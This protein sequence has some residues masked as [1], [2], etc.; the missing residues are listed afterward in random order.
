M[1]DDKKKGI[2]PNTQNRKWL[3][4]FNNPVEHN[5]THEELKV[6]L[7]KI[8]GALYWCMCDEI[9]GKTQTY[10]TH[11][12]LY[13]SS[14][15]KF[16]Q[17]KKMF[18]SAH[19]DY[20]RGTNQEN[21]DYIRKEGK[22][23][24]SDKKETN[25]IDTFEESGECPEENQGSRNDLNELYDMI[26]NDYST[27]QILEVNPNYMKQIGTI[28]RI[29]EVLRYEEFKNKRRLDLHVEYW[30]GASGTGKSRNIRDEF[31]DE[32]VY[33]VVDT[34]HPWDGY[35]G[36]DVVIFDD[37]RDDMFHLVELLRWLDVYPIELRCRYQNKQACFTK[38]YFTSNVAFDCLYTYFQREE[39]ESWN[40]FCRRF[41]CIKKFENGE[42]GVHITEYESVDKYLKRFTPG[43]NGFMKVPDEEME[44]IKMM[45]GGV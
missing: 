19:V 16:E 36:Q 14:P 18:P 45:F 31:G 32:N 42:N 4:T 20:V 39:K 23:E 11:L 8:K 33:S 40:A 22:Y 27:Y 21:R 9:G 1:S 17:I 5:A 38:V 30:Y 34:L 15:F 29:R 24:N 43:E 41:H 26:K 44:Q 37:F 25:L 3:L 13:R 6:I 35:K 2:K 10:H 7:G 28:D 12:F